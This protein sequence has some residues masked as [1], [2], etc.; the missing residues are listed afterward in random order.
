MNYFWVNQAKFDAEKEGKHLRSFVTDRR[1]HHG[2]LAILDMKVGDGCFS[3]TRDGLVSINQIQ[4]LAKIVETTPEGKT[5][6]ISCSY[7]PLE[8]II[9]LDELKKL[10]DKRFSFTRSEAKSL[11]TINGDRVQSYI[12]PLSEEQVE[13][14]LSL[15]KQASPV[16]SGN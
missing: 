9:S 5:Y 15:T 10:Y 8:T 2:R 12:I 4:E 16:L 7:S 6:Q 3:V 13:F 14:L 11:F 1:P